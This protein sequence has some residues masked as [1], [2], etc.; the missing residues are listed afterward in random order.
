MRTGNGRW[1]LVELEEVCWFT[2]AEGESSG[3]DDLVAGGEIEGVDGGSFDFLEH[4]V[5]VGRRRAVAREDAPHEGEALQ[6]CVVGREDEDRDRESD[7]RDEAAGT[8]ADG[9]DDDG[10]HLG[11]LLDGGRD[12]D[13]EGASGVGFELDRMGDGGAAGVAGFGAVDNVIH[14]RHDFYGMASDCGLGG[15]HEGIGAVPDGVGDIGGLGAGRTLALDHRLEHLSGDDDRQQGASGGFDDLSLEH[16]HFGRANFDAQ[17]AAGDHD[18]VGDGDDLL[19][20]VDGGDGFDLGDERD[21]TACCVNGGAGFG[22][23]EGAADEGEGEEIESV[24]DGEANVLTVLVG[25]SG[26]TLARSG[27]V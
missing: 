5:D 3:E 9:E 1:D 21:L 7:V 14:H 6:G 10:L 17:V 2:L 23:V 22:Q 8:T 15:E 4:P 18:A 11:V 24:P 16:G 27:R 13:G 20:V 12:R 26:Q 19:Q 25:H